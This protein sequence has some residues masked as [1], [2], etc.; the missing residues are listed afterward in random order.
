MV[1]VRYILYVVLLTIFNSSVIYPVQIKRS[2]KILFVLTY[3]PETVST[4]ILNQITGLIDRGHNVYIYSKQIGNIQHAHPDISRYNLID[5]TY[6]H[7]RK[8]LNNL[9]P[10]SKHF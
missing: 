10:R 6:F 1:Y 7:S 2:L 3:F 4:A 5:R 8:P 9:P